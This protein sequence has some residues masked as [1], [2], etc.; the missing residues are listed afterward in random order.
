MSFPK[1]TKPTT[2]DLDV[3]DVINFFI[4]FIFSKITSKNIKSS[5]IKSSVINSNQIAVLLIV[6]FNE[7]YKIIQQLLNQF[8]I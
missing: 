5:C 2:A 3:L 6:A 4:C 8:V 7:S 1:T